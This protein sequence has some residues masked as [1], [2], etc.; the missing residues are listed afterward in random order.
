MNRKD[1]EYLERYL[2]KEK[3]EEGISLLAQGK[4]PQYIVGNVDFYGNIMEVNSDVL[5]PR[6]ETELLVERTIFYAKKIWVG[7]NC[8]DLS[9]LDIGTGSGCIAITL[10]KELG[11]QVVGVDI[12]EA[13]LVVARRNALSNQV[14]IKFL[15]SDIFSAVSER[16]D[17][18]VSNPPYI[19][20]NEEIEEIVYNNEP[21]LALFAEEEGLYFYKMILE[22][23]SGYVKQN[24][25][26]ALEIGQTQGERV[27][28][29][30]YRYFS[31]VEVIIEKDYSGRDRFVFVYRIREDQG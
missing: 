4:A 9:I 5:I 25:L 14:A 10:K 26:I 30:V 12:S 17:I 7:E 31:D 23:A 27:K 13:A 24:F 6:F 11:C 22:Q 20:R 21:H 28:S 15:K 1:I 19:S 8:R 3:L 2:D 16:F 29:L 18:I